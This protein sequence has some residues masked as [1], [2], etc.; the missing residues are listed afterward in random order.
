MVHIPD[1]PPVFYGA[2]GLKP[3]GHL[4]KRIF[5]APDEYSK[6]KTPL[7]QVRVRVSKRICLLVFTVLRQCGMP[8]KISCSCGVLGPVCH[9]LIVTPFAGTQGAVSSLIHCVRLY[10]AGCRQ[11]ES[12][13][14]PM[15][16]VYA[17]RLVFDLFNSH[18][19]PDTAHTC[20]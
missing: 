7:N 11:K 10:S 6:I 1:A 14:D 4:P 15:S 3:S 20:W 9:L 18:T 8:S 17:L 16:V 5:H 2:A 19:L 13:F 12:Y